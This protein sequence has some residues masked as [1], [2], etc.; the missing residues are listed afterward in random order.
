MVIN[1]FLFP[2]V[3]ERY[4]IKFGQAVSQKELEK[5][6]NEA[7]HPEDPK[8]FHQIKARIELV[9]EIEDAKKSETC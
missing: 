6:L 9:G 8:K 4:T 7:K 1:D 5:A 3:I 2:F